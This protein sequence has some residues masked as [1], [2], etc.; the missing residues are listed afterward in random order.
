MNRRLKFLFAFPFFLFFLLITSC[1]NE[2]KMNTLLN[3]NKT[4][5]SVKIGDVFDVELSFVNKDAF[6]T[7]KVIKAINGKV[8]TSYNKVI[9]VATI[10]NPYKFEEN[11]VNGDEVA[12]VVYSFIGLDAA[13]KQL[14]AMDLVLNVD[15]AYGPLLLKYDWGLVSQMI[16]GYEFADD[17]A[18]DDVYRFNADKS[19]QLDWGT[20]FSTG[21]SE[22]LNSYCAWKP[23]G[24]E[25][26]IDSLYMIK[27]NIFNP[28]VANITKYKVLK[29]ENREMI[30]ETRQDWSWLGLANDEKVIEKYEPKSK[31]PSFNPYGAQDASYVIPLCNPGNY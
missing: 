13:G 14:D 29:M 11:V 21:G 3:L 22:A 30:L 7:I 1:S 8:V 24:N 4:K 23:I 18:K 19:W 15:I 28:A 17:A 5:A 26:K 16:A 25:A 9:D 2:E 6:H 20:K 10:S 12:T 27:Y 31:L